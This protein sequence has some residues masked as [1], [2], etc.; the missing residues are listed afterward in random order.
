M[1]TKL[2]SKQHA[3][4]I[5]NLAL[6][7][8][9]FHKILINTVNRTFA[10]R[11]YQKLNV[12]LIASNPLFT[13]LHPPLFLQVWRLPVPHNTPR[14]CRSRRL[15]LPPNPC[16]PQQFPGQPPLG[17]KRQD[18]PT[19]KHN[20][21]PVRIL[22]TGLCGNPPPLGVALQTCWSPQVHV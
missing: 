18:S 20:L 1:W 21:L 12:S 3:K 22:Q 11:T 4:A 19:K 2:L 14:R 17:R 9:N 15:G 6:R 5:L 8:Y 10:F 13:N 16:N 7:A